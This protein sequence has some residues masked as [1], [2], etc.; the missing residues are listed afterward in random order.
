MLA[1]SDEALAR[2]IRAARQVS[3]KK[4]HRW[5]KEIADRLDPPVPTVVPSV[6]KARSPAAARQARVRQ[7][8]RNGVHMYRLPLRDV[9]VEGLLSM[10]IASGR[11]TERDALNH[12]RI[13]AELARLLEAQ[14]A[15]WLR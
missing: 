12:Q 3:W 15:R 1:L 6:T 14:G 2:V 4:R 9:C 10:M 8:R 13:E 11:L 7:R 5:L